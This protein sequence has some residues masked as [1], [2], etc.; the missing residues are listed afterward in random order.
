[1]SEMT[2]EQK[3]Y[4]KMTETPVPGLVAKLAVPTIISMLTTAIYNM[5]DTFFVSQLGTS[6]AG[7]V[8]IVFSLMALIQAVGFMLGMGSGA[9]ISRLLGQQEKKEADR[10]G[11]TAFFTALAFGLVLT[12]GGLA[13]GE[14]LMKALGSTDTILP[15]AQSYAQYI[16]F[17]APIMCASFVLNNILRSQ[18]RATLSMIGIATGGVLNIALDPICIFVFGWGI[19]GAAIATLFSQCV[20]FCIMLFFFLSGRSTVHLSIRS[21]SRDP[22]TYWL[23]IKTGL[24]SLFRQGL[25]SIATVALNVSAA[26]YGD[27]A[28]AA[29]SIVGRIMMLIGS[30]MIGFGQGYMPVVGFNYGAKKYDRVRQAFRFALVVGSIVLAV[31]GGIGFLL[32]PQVMTWFRADDRAVIEI[33]SFAM[34]CQCATLMFQPLTV[35]SNMT[36][37]TVG[38]S[39]Q[40]TFVSSCRQGVFFLPFIFLLPA[41]FSL[42]GVQITQTAADLCTFVVCIPFLMSFFRKLKREEEGAAPAGAAQ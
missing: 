26:V 38:L 18:G 22:R 39:W 24:P 36:F 12:A 30:A 8:G 20:S 4:Q 6:A 37:Q 35:L 27:A 7:A 13:W 33:G 21:V 25:A 9:N 31:L 5:A 15:Y 23:I 3:Q 17:G 41:F 34:R 10:V 40:A 32:A 19:A 2:P 29:M 11:S 1:M 16:L 28:V 42:T 14:G